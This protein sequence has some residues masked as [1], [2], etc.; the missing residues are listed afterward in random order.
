M[1]DNQLCK[2]CMINYLRIFIQDV[3]Q[4]GYNWWL[5]T[6]HL[7]SELKNI[8][9]ATH[10]SQIYISIKIQLSPYR[11]T[12]CTRIHMPLYIGSTFEE[13][14]QEFIAVRQQFLTNY[15]HFLLYIFRH[16]IILAFLL[17]VLEI[18]TNISIK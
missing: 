18:W 8:D 11:P 13:L 14:H 12:C 2:I 3:V 7:S 10:Y 16:I 6:T 15:L 1:I 4:I 9:T 5:C 17:F